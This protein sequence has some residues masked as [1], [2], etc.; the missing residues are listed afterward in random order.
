MGRSCCRFFTQSLTESLSLNYPPNTNKFAQ[1]QKQKQTQTLF[2]GSRGSISCCCW[3]CCCF[4][5]LLVLVLRW[6]ASI[7]S[8]SFFVF[9]VCLCFL[10]GYIHTHTM[11][12]WSGHAL[13]H[14]SSLSSSIFLSF[15]QKIDCLR[16]EEAKQ[17]K[18][19]TRACT[20]NKYGKKLQIFQLRWERRKS[21]ESVESKRKEKKEERKHDERAV[22]WGWRGM[23]RQVFV[24]S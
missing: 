20:T 4:A 11:K 6:F 1:T 3:C 18:C 5:P 24:A 9:V 21:T 23:K 10:R 16:R 15:I 2:P 8:L 17:N 7:F 19:T 14:T 13:L 12:N 22:F